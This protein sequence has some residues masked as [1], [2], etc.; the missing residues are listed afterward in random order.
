MQSKKNKKKSYIVIQNICKS[1]ESFSEYV[2]CYDDYTPDIDNAKVFD[3]VIDAEKNIDNHG[4]G[5]DEK[6]F[7]LTEAEYIIKML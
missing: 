6:I 7:I 2:D 4:I 5:D 1:D 3:S